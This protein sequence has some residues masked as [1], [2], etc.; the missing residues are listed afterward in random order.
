M[1]AVVTR[2]Q[3]PFHSVSLWTRAG[4]GGVVLIGVVVTCHI[5]PDPQFSPLETL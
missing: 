3:A 1:Q 4:A 5:S 2:G